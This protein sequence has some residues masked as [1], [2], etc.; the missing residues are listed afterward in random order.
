MLQATCAHH[1]R[2]AYLTGSVVSDWPAEA[3]QGFEH[4][5]VVCIDDVARLIGHRDHEEALFHLYQ[6]ALDTGACLVFAARSSARGLDFALPDLASRLRAA[7]AYDVQA[8]ADDDAVEA[9]TARAKRR[10]VTLPAATA[11][12]LLSRYERDMHSLCTLL[13]ELDLASLAARRALTVP[14]VKSILE[15]V[16]PALS[17]DG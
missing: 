3:W 14:F 10:G 11:R 16:P 9:L 15:S 1:D 17:G 8:L 12:Y 6:R 2:A 4:Y 13:D 7:R 5:T